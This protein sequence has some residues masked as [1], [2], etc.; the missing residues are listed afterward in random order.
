[1]ASRTYSAGAGHH[2]REDIFRRYE[3]FIADFVNRWPEPT[4]LRPERLAPTTVAAQFRSAV[5]G[6]LAHGYHT[7]IDTEKL[8]Q[9]W[10][11][12]QVKLQNDTVIICSRKTVMPAIDSGDPTTPFFVTI[13]N[14][15]AE[16]LSAL[17]VLH[18][19]G[20][21]LSPSCLRGNFPLWQTPPDITV[22]R[23][24]DGTFLML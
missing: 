14:P 11:E 5:L 13:D 20:V 7:T 1:M 16:Q 4:V 8:T 15:T 24:P 23:Q 18:R 17:A 19:T 22:A 2:A 3:R 6:L 21:A 12:A 9:V 10:S